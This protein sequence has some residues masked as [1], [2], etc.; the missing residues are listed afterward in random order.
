MVSDQVALSPHM[1]SPLQL[2]MLAWTTRWLYPRAD[3]RVMCAADAAS[4]LAR[5]SGLNAASFEIITNPVEPPGALATNARVE[6]LWDGAGKGQK[7]G[8]S[9]AA[10]S[11]A[12]KIR[13]CCCVLL[14][15]PP[16]GPKPG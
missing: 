3:V 14:R 2:R 11:S 8:S 13:R 10:R 16:P 4:D 12:R 9:T 15:R 6:A 5:V 1:K 7:A